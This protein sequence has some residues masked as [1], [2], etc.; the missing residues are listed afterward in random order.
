MGAAAATGRK[1]FALKTSNGTR[2]RTRQYRGRINRISDRRGIRQRRSRIAT[3]V[4]RHIAAGMRSSNFKQR[5]RTTFGF[6]DRKRAIIDRDSFASAAFVGAVM[7]V[8]VQNEADLEAVD[9]LSEPRRAKEGEYFG[10]LACIAAP[11]AETTSGRA[12]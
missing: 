9:R 10:W 2:E 11:L 8:A 4:S 12:S 7:R 3:T 1:R 5:V 6:R